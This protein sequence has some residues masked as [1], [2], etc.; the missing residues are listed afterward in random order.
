MRFVR[1]GDC[2]DERLQERFEARE[3]KRGRA[4]NL[5]PVSTIVGASDLT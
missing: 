4:I 3:G 1:E 2:D 5:D